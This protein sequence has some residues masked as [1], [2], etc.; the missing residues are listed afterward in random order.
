MG[1]GAESA[2]TWD[3]GALQSV[4]FRSGTTR[5]STR[6]PTRMGRNM[7]RAGAKIRS[8]LW[9]WRVG[10]GFLAIPILDDVRMWITLFAFI[11]LYVDCICVCVDVFGVDLEL[12]SW[13]PPKKI[14]T[15]MSHYLSMILPF[16]LFG[17][18]YRYYRCI[19]TQSIC[20]KYISCPW[21]GIWIIHDGNW[22]M[23]HCSHGDKLQ[24]EI[25]KKRLSTAKYHKRSSLVF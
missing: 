11:C 3:S 18:C 2:K 7:A 17:V 5:Q 8:S 4:T 6:E 23:C 20:I 12:L 13:S 19:H 1:F 24:I 21:S 15:V 16:Y 9:G 14:E 25:H 22:N 10:G